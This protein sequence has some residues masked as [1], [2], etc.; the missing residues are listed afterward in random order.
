MEKAHLSHTMRK[1]D[2]F[3]PEL[4]IQHHLEDSVDGK[5]DPR[6]KLWQQNV[7]ELGG[8]SEAQIEE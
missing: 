4:N 1:R 5:G 2:K 8:A 7:D 6:K 3:V